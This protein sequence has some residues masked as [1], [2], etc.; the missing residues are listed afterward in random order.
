M[1]ILPIGRLLHSIV[2]IFLSLPLPETC[3][4]RRF[5]RSGVTMK[6]LKLVSISVG[7]SVFFPVA[8]RRAPPAKANTSRPQHPRC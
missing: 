7:L 5:L 8:R 4:S 1:R 6:T 3:K 2:L